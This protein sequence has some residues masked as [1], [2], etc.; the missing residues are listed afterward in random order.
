[1]MVVVMRLDLLNRR[2]MSSL[3]P[4]GG[5]GS[6]SMPLHVLLLLLLLL[7]VVDMLLVMVLSGSRTV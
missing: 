6:R 2:V 1:M 3:G 4:C 7:M 5:S